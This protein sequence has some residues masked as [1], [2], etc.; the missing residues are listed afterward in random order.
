LQR[1]RDETHRVAT[2]RN[3]NLRTKENT[4][5]PFVALPHVGA[6]RDKILMKKYGTLEALAQA[7][8]S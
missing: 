6:E 4:V 7:P 1:V 3:Q 8:E 2:S 5:T